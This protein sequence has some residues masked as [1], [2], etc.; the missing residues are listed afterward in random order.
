MNEKE[1]KPVYWAGDPKVCELTHTPLGNE[2]I[3]GRTVFGPWAIMSP[4][5]HHDFGVGLGMGR[6]QRYQK[7]ADGKWLK[8][9]G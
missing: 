4:E 9:E 2:F 3:D 1:T 5:A 6:G 8:V 7:Q